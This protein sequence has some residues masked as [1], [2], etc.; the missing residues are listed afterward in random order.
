MDPVGFSASLATLIALTT[1]TIRYL[2]DVKHAL[3]E[4]RSLLQEATSLLQMLIDLQNKVD[5]PRQPRM[6]FNDIKVLGT[7]NGPLDQLREALEKLCK[8]LKTKKGVKNTGNAFTWALDKD[9]CNEVLRRIERVKS[10]IS[11]ISLGK[12]GREVVRAIKTETANIDVIKEGVASLHIKEDEKQRRE[13]LSWF[14]PLDFFK[15]QQDNFMRHVEGTG[16]WL[17]DSEAFRSWL[18]GPNHTLCCA[19]IPGAGKSVLASIVVDFLQKQYTSNRSIAT[20]AIYCN[21]KEMEVQSPENLIASL[22]VQILE[23]YA[24]APQALVKIYESHKGKHSRPRLDDVLNIFKAITDPLQDVYIVVDALDECS[25]GVGIDLIR[26]LKALTF[27]IRLLITTRPIDGIIR[28]LNTQLLVEV[29]ANQDDLDKYA[30]S[31]IASSTRLG[32]LLS[33][34]TALEK[35]MRKKVI[36]KAN[37]M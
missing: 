14:S 12:I 13:I 19:G 37:R 33:K 18:T 11:L 26:I 24:P 5:E 16:Q 21:F 30:L 22:C 2:S 29:L 4:R 35:S 8:K 34:D 7:E 20:A 17:I 31:R 9:S 10:T 28:E 36:V 23:D 6:W 15:T 1:K 3:N 32:A 27:K 25:L